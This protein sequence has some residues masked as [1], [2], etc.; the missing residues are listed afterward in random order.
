MGVIALSPIF[1][2]KSA[3]IVAQGLIDIMLMSA[4]T[5]EIVTIGEK[6]FEHSTVTPA[7]RANDTTDIHVIRESVYPEAPSRPFAS[8]HHRSYPGRQIPS[9]Q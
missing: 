8:D 2:T 5:S 4:S 3:Q 1:E 7:V 6:I 9:T